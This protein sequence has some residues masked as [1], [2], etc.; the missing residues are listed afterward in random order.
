VSD[1]QHR[2]ASGRDGGD[3]LPLPAE[4][5]EQQRI[6]LSGWWERVYEEWRLPVLRYVHR[7]T[8]DPHLAE[9]VAHEAFLRLMSTPHVTSSSVRSPG[10]WLFHVATN[11]VRDSARR[12]GT[13]ER[14]ATQLVH[15]TMRPEWPDMAI[16]REESVREARSALDTLRQRDREVLLM[17]D[18]GLTYDEIAAALEIQPQSVP[19]VVMRALR[20]FRTA[21]QAGTTT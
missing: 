13:R 21:Y 17:R 15:E 16:E 14:A 11:I 6:A 5:T 1:A 19:S 2:R 20:R 9:D 10:S 18:A 4:T 12:S 7:L 8:G 3:A